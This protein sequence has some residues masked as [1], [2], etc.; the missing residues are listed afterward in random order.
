MIKSPRHY[1]NFGINEDLIYTSNLAEDHILCILAIV[2]NKQYLIEI[3]LSQAH[4]V[5]EHLEPQKTSKYVCCYYW[6]PCIVQDTELYCKMCLICQTTK[7]SM[8]K[9]PG[10][11][12]SLL[13]PIKPWESIVM[14]FIGPFSK[15]GSFDYLWVVICCLTSMVHLVP[16]CTTTTASELA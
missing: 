8:Q 2:C 3:I 4:Q 14:D 13:I 11:L 7:F 5:L 12:H 15:S 1:K 9:V 16:I 10:L 6:W